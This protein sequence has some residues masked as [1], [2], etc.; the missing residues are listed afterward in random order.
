MKAVLF[1]VSYAGYWGQHTLVPHLIKLL[2]KRAVKAS[3]AFA[4][5]PNT[6]RDRKKLAAQLRSE[7]SQLHAEP[8]DV[9]V[10]V[11]ATGLAAASY[12]GR[13]EMVRAS[14]HRFLQ[15]VTS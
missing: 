14:S 6:W 9:S 3:V 15:E 10:A 7:V 4:K 8:S 13:G 12:H 5:V 11:K 1:S 2:S